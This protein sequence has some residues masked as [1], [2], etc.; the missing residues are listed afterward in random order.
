[1]ANCGLSLSLLFFSINLRKSDKERESREREGA[2]VHTAG[3]VYQCV[4]VCSISV[5]SVVYWCLCECVVPVVPS[6]HQFT[7]LVLGIPELFQ[8]LLVALVPG[9]RALQRG[10]LIGQLA[11]EVT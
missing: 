6:L 5:C 3:P 1:M 8:A 2:G 11:G 10:H 9:T 4:L 7:Q